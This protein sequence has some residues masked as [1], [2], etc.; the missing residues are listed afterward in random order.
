MLTAFS[1]SLSFL[2]KLTVWGWYYKGEW[3]RSLSICMLDWAR[4]Y[5]RTLTCVLNSGV[6]WYCTGRPKCRGFLYFRGSI[7]RDSTVRSYT[8]TVFPWRENAGFKGKRL[9][10]DK[11]G[12]QSTLELLSKF[13]AVIRLY[14]NGVQQQQ[15]KLQLGCGLYLEAIWYLKLL[16]S[17]VDINVFCEITTWVLDGK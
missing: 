12:C 13:C 9:F 16:A 17:G 4:H 3:E 11:T 6:N 14:H 15:K 10:Y 1:S 8:I 7:L 2:F 5:R